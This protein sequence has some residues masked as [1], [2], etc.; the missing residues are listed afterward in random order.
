MA[1]TSVRFSPPDTA[2]TLARRTAAGV[3]IAVVA[4]LGIQ[5]VVDAVGV[6][7]GASGPMTP[8]AAVP[9]IGTS[10]VAG[11]GAAIAYAALA[12]FT[13]RPGRNF[14]AVAV[15]VFAVMLLP[16]LLVT[17]SM[18]VTPAGQALLV[19]YHLVVAVSLVGF[20]G[21]VVEV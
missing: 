15:A 19:V 17:P 9:L 20:V 4:L 3:G 10:I 18:G 14:V 5:I 8:F 7:L 13:D 21:G 1:Q 6:E 12:R 16:V 2:T 11:I